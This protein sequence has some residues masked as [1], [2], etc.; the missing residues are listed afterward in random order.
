[1][2]RQLAV[3]SLAGLGLTFT[4]GGCAAP[5][6]ANVCQIPE[7]ATPAERLAAL[8]Q[9]TPSTEPGTLSL[10]QDIDI[11]FVIDNSPSMTPKQKAL[12]QNIPKFMQ[13]IDDTGASYH[14]GI[15]TSDVGT[16][17]SKGVFWGGSIGKCDTFAGDDGMLQTA[18]CTT[19]TDITTE[20]QAACNTLCPDPQYVP[21]DG[22]RFI[23]KIDGITNVPVKAEADPMTGVVGDVGPIKAFQCMAL[24]GDSGCGVEG[25]LEGAKRA[26]DGHLLENSG[27]L[28]PD[29][30][31]AVIYITDEDDCS[32]QLAKRSQNNPATRD[33][34]P[35][36]PD[37]ADCYNIDYRCLARSIQCNESLLTPGVKTG[38]MERPDNYLDPV[39]KYYNFFAALRP[40]TQLLVSGIWTLPSISG[41]GR[42]E[43]VQP[44]G[45][46][47]TAQLNR[48]HAT[49]A[50]CSYAKDPN[51]FGQA[52]YRLSAF[53]GM[54][55]KSPDGSPSALEVSICDIDNYPTALDK[56]A[57]AIAD[58]IYRCLP[59]TPKTQNGKT[60]CVVGDVDSSTPHASPAVTFPACSSTCCSAFAASSQPT[61]ADPAIQTACAAETTDA[62]YCATKSTAPTTPCAGTA[63]MGVWRKG[64]AA[65]PAGKS[66]TFNCAGGG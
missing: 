52:Q 33:C 66:T 35:S 60:V 39:A 7:N 9:C 57:G 19:R 18:A 50:S 22:N 34:D 13:K 55:G 59:S 58:K 65:T 38:C 30:I 43:I 31:L 24:V 44:L 17:P 47:G 10:R 4:L 28:R 14:V 21:R 56:I 5:P 63:V 8:A 64:G 36:Q 15:V 54:F 42:V 23:A 32:V 6:L 45:A 48:A 37:A 11:L 40:P 1:M 26:L 41:G 29:S 49:G 53:A 51:I 3:Y 62:C 16:D 12:A 20:A 61:P 46:G 27:F 2:R 25:Q